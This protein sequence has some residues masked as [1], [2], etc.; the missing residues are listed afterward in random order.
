[1]SRTR[2]LW[3]LWLLAALAPPAHADEATSPAKKPATP[4]ATPISKP[5]VSVEPA[6]KTANA[7]SPATGADEEFLEFLGSVDTDTGDQDW[8]DYLAQTDVSKVAQAKKNAP[9]AP[10]GK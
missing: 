8:I 1:M 2:R 6:A 9:E 7:P 3:L 5:P 10:E 4:A